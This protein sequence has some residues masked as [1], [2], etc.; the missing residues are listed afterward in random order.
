MSSTSRNFSQNI[1][2]NR[3]QQFFF[4]QLIGWSGYSLVTFFGITFWD[5][6]I[7]L[8]HI[9]HIVLQA[10]LGLVAS[11]PLRA[12]YR[13]NFNLRIGYR[14]LLA[15]TASVFFS[16]IWTALRMYTFILMS[17]ESG[18]WSEFNLWYFGSLFV[19]LSWTALYFGIK[20]YQLLGI[21]HEKLLDVSEQQNVEKIKRLEA[22][23]LARNAQLEMLRY[24]LNPHFLFNTLNS[25]NALV[26]LKENNRA[27]KMILLLS[28]FLRHSLD[29]GSIE[30]ITL[31][32]EL[33]TLM[34][35]LD[36]E[37]VRFDGRLKLDFDIEPQALQAKLPGLILQPL[38]ENSMDHAIAVNEDGGVIR[39]RARKVRNELQ[40][41]LSDTGPGKQVTEKI[42]SKGVGLKNTMERL[43]TL[44]GSKYHFQELKRNADGF[45][46]QIMIPYETEGGE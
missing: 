8:S 35:Y 44:Y 39:L 30:K 38:I 43:K 9:G 25:I 18:L 14:L 6:N 1:Y 20:Y 4:F 3:D 21:E 27:Q 17:G 15:V 33:A 32:Q 28:Q 11:W 36:I 12:I 46:V 40:I 34:L 22:E 16:A 19:F 2:E 31:E 45:S 10:L 29:Q 13:R 7:T 37:L 26:K 5:N 41:E 24:Q 23:S 42:K